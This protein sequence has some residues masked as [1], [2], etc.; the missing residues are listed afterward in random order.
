MLRRNKYKHNTGLASYEKSKVN[1]I[2][3]SISYKINNIFEH[4]ENM[5]KLY[6]IKELLNEHLDQMTK[7]YII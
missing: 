7:L 2:T 5:T 3:C 4:L 1:I 6:N